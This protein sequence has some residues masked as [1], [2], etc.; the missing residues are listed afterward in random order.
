M[1]ATAT[2]DIF[3]EETHM[4]NLKKLLLLATVL[5]L[6][7]SLAACG[8][9]TGANNQ[10]SENK[11]G[12]DNGQ[13]DDADNNAAPVV[14]EPELPDIQFNG[15]KFRL[16][17]TKPDAVT[18]LLTQITSGEE[19]GDVFNDAVYRRNRIIEDR[20][21]IEMVEIVANDP[22]DAKNKGQKSAK[23]GSD[24]YDLIFAYIGDSMGMAQSG[25]LLEANSIPYMDLSKPWWDKDVV[26][27]LSICGKL[28]GVAGDLCFA[29]YSAVMPMFFNKKMLSDLGLENPYQLVRD[30]KWTLDKFADMSKDASLDLDGNGKW[31]QNDQYGFMSLNFL[32]YPSLILSAGERFVTKDANDVPRFTAGSPRFVDVYEKIV[33]ILNAGDNRFFDADAAGNHRYQ[34]TMFPGN[35]ALFWHELM[36]WSKILRDMESDFGILPTPKYD[37]AQTTYY[38]RVFNATMMAIPVTVTDIDRTGIILEALCAESY[39][40]V[41]PVYYDTMLKTKTARDEESGE[42][43]DIIFANRIYDMAYLYWEGSTYSPYTAMARSGKKEV[44]SYVEK[45]SSKAEAAIQKTITAIEA[46]D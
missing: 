30:G 42:M 40:S 29:H 19:T 24:D 17:N 14:I 32:V 33:D 35:Q 46:L 15:Y 34:D 37:E 43:L 22:G 16:I 28:F 11:A 31:D 6:I 20:Y 23:S 2:F 7:I 4:T 39:K 26:N 1:A 9:K 21:G 12:A 25:L 3:E 27:D 36:N 44:A 10:N 18:W 38:S 45:N 13:N 5:I 8:D 41:K